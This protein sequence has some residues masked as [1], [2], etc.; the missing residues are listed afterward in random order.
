MV[1]EQTRHSSHCSCQVQHGEEVQQKQGWDAILKNGA[2]VTAATVGSPA[3][4]M[5]ACKMLWKEKLLHQGEEGRRDERH[6]KKEVT[7][8]EE[9]CV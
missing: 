6:E 9:V 2:C 1:P 4:T 5:E 3:G 8:P 7:P